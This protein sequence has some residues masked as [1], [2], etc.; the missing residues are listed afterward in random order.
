MLNKRWNLSSDYLWSV[1]SGYVLI[2]LN[3]IAQVLLMPLYIKYLGAYKYGVF[4]LVFSFINYAAIGIGFMSGGALRLLSEN[5][6]TNNQQ[7]L[8]N[9][10]T[11]SKFTYIF[12]SVLVI[13][14]FIC[15]ALFMKGTDY[16]S[17]DRA[18]SLKIIC[19]T[20]FYILIK[21]DF[22]IEIQLFVGIQKQRLANVFQI[23]SQILYL[24]TVIPYMLTCPTNI[25]DILF[26]NLLGIFLVKLIIIVYKRIKQLNIKIVKYD[27]SFKPLMKKLFGKMG[28]GYAIYG[29]III[30]YQADML[31]M[32]TLSDNAEIITQYA[33]IWK[34]AEA[35]IMLLWKIPETMQPYIIELDA[36]KEYDTLTLQYSRI[37]RISLLLSTLAAVGFAVFGRLFIKIWMG[38]NYIPID[39]LTIM[40]AA[41]AIFFDGVK[42]TPAIYAYSLVRLKELNVVSGLETALKCILIV[43]LFP[44]IG[45]LAPLIVRNLLAVGGFAYQYWR[46]GKRLLAYS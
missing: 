9:S 17:K 5:Y 30:T 39:T 19:I 14:A 31:L 3:M 46:M 40:L 29:L 43:I 45:I 36:R 2:A 15:Y 16:F 33:M 41:L 8:S 32:G 28:L 25:S 21:Y 11:V 6:S 34:V 18:E 13:S 20:C 22:S 23:L 12:Y 42:R 38:N 4:L 37:Y 44:R 26:F 24:V 7:N 27:P 10:Y 35:G 1:V